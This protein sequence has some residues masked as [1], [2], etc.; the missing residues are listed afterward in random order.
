MYHYKWFYLVSLGREYALGMDQPL[1]CSS[2]KQHIIK[3]SCFFIGMISTLFLA[4]MLIADWVSFSRVYPQPRLFLIL[5]INF[6]YSAWTSYHLLSL[7]HFVVFLQ[8]SLTVFHRGRK[9]KSGGTKGKSSRA[10]K[11]L[12]FP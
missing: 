3:N 2:I 6:S 5:T 11:Q 8:C 12:C 1:P 7:L 9:Q 10:D 4:Q